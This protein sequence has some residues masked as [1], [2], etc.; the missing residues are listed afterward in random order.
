MSADSRSRDPGTPVFTIGFGQ[1]PAEGFFATLR[2]A[3]IRR[4]LDVRLHNTSQLSGFS[5]KDDLQFFLRELCGA[6]YVHQPLLAPSE[7]LLG[8]YRQKRLTWAEYE[9]GFLELIAARQIERELSSGFFDVPTVLL[10]SEPTA[11]HCHRRVVLDYLD[12]RWG[13]LTVT[14]LVQRR[15]ARSR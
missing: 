12:Q 6:E 1:W 5:K 8:A 13:R 14:H 11:E 3:G 4:L 2:E 10:C 7:E 9:Q 15:V